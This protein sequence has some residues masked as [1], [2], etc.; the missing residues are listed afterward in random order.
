MTEH[1]WNRKYEPVHEIK[2]DAALH[3]TSPAFHAVSGCD[4]VSLS[5]LGMAR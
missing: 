3:S 1:K 4:T 5:L 2:L